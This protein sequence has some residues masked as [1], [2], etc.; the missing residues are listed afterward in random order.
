MHMNRVYPSRSA[1]GESA[2][3]DGRAAGLVEDLAA[4]IDAS[5]ALVQ[6]SSERS[7]TSSGVHG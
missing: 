5:P 7:G 6:S 3:A 4:F 2:H 1:E